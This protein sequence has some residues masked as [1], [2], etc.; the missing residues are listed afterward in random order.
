MHCRVT[1]LSEDT[2]YSQWDIRKSAHETASGQNEKPVIGDSHLTLLERKRDL[3]QL[4]VRQTV[5][6]HGW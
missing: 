1:R 2:A 4:G 6:F 5:A 3:I